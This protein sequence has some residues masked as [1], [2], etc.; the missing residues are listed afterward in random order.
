MKRVPLILGLLSHVLRT[1]GNSAEQKAVVAFHCIGYINTPRVLFVVLNC[2]TVL[3]IRLRIT[4]LCTIVMRAER[5][6][7]K[8]SL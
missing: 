1:H 3:S 7:S 5:F 2:L 4:V 6:L 8:G